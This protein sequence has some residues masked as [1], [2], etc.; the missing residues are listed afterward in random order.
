M[1]WSIFDL[2][3]QDYDIATLLLWQSDPGTYLYLLPI[4]DKNANVLNAADNRD[5][6]NLTYHKNTE[7]VWQTPSGLNEIF[8]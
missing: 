6:K 4:T 7:D 2:S 5:V 8:F 1:R 3:K